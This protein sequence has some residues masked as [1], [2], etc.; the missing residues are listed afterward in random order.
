MKP[1]T[2]QEWEKLARIWYWLGSSEFWRL[3]F[4]KKKDEDSDLFFNVC[5]ENRGY[6]HVQA[7]R[8]GMKK[9]GPKI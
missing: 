4:M 6:A 8:E 9:Q 1:I 5:I 2:Q 7:L 3:A